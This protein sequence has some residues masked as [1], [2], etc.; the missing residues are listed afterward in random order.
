MPATADSLRDLHQLHQRAKALRDRLASG[1][2]TVAGRMAALTTRQADLEAAKKA[3]QDA[4]VQLSK[5][6]HA[7]KGVESKIDDLKVKLNTVKKNDEYKAIQNQIA[8]DV[9]SKSKIEEE[10]INAMD[11]NEARAVEFKKLEDEVKR[12]T[13]ETTATKK[14]VEDQAAG[15]KQQLAEIEAAIIEAESLIPD[16]FRDRYRRIVGRYGADA[17]AACEDGACL[18]CFTSVTTQMVNELINNEALVFC[19]SCGRLLYLPEPEIH[20][21]QRTGK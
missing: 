12:F 21:T 14:Q 7:L 20:N 1:P 10:I 3:L 16:D 9:N 5:H 6:E 2:K 4:K 15:Q 13:A 11:V 19:L 8:H 18:G 17:L